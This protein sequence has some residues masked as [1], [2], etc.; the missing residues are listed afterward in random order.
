MKLFWI[1]LSITLVSGIV[2]FASMLQFLYTGGSGW[3]MTCFW[4]FVVFVLSVKPT[5]ELADPSKEEVTVI[6]IREK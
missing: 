6:V 5:C 1:M 2:G 3:L 4:S